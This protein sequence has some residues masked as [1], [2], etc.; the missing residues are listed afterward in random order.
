MKK[1]LF[2]IL[3]F[4]PHISHGEK[5]DFDT[6][7]RHAASHGKWTRHIE[8]KIYESGYYRFLTLIHGREDPVWSLIIQWINLPNEEVRKGEIISQIE[9]SELKGSKFTT[10]QCVTKKCD[11]FYIIATE[12]IGYGDTHK[13]TLTFPKVGKYVITNDT[14]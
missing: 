2:V 7:L 8:N 10:P 6:D 3:L 13:Y 1:L 4:I 12:H 11:E 5:Y 14:L 9:V